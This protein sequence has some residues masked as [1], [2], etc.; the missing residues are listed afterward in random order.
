MNNAV[1]IGFCQ[2][3]WDVGIR[4]SSQAVELVFK[5]EGRP[6]AGKAWARHFWQ[7]NKHGMSE[8]CFVLL[9]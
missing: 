2:Q 7:R 6:C 8:N 5:V 3:E 1:L 4:K 9:G